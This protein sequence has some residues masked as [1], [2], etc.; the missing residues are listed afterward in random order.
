MPLVVFRVPHANAARAGVVLH[1]HAARLA[2]PGAQ[3]AVVALLGVLLCAYTRRSAAAACRHSAST[4]PHPH[5]A[6]LPLLGVV[7][8]GAH[9]AGGLP[10][11]A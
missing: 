4:R 2:L 7:L 9:A 11:T 6:R 10:C 8:R 1:A 5:A 3:I